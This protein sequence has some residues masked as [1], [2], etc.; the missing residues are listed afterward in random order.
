M[1]SFEPC[2]SDVAVVCGNHINAH[3]LV[4]N[5]ERIG[6]PGRIVLLRQ[7]VEGA[8]LAVC[9]NPQV[10]HWA[11]D[12]RSHDDLPARIEERYGREGRAVV[13]FTDERYHP[14]FAAWRRLHP[15]SPL[16][17]HLGS[18]A[19][20][21]AV[22]DRY[23]FCRF[24]ADRRLASVPRTIRGDEDPF[25]AFGDSFVVRPRL[26]WFGVAQRERVTLVKGPAEFRAAV[27]T[28]AS[29]GLRTEDLSFQELLS[30]RNRDNV[31]ISGWYGPEVRH[32]FC[33]RK[34]LQYPPK[35][36]GGDVVEL[37]SPPPGVMEQAQDVLAALSYEGPFELEFVFD[38]NAREFKVTELNPRFWLQQGLIEAASGCALIRAYLG[39][40][41]LPA[42]EAEQ[43]LRYWVNPLY[44]LYR[45]RNLDFRGLAYW[46]S[47]RAWA[48]F[49]L[50][51]AV[52]Y[53]WHYARR[54]VCHAQ[55]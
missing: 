49:S 11:A 10:E 32:L 46:S 5:L 47:R 53:G 2:K 37:V 21:T 48:P 51:E 55:G 39:Q 34:I 9:L 54:K 33:S 14:A 18:V 15:E 41:P 22:L 6:W 42:T 38:E 7:E 44:A 30:I 1:N 40:A 43:E 27:E 31:S 45:A 29:R 35:T 28:Y 24:I 16:R 4:R 36:G 13:F 17:F 23:E 25:A 26:S 19:H 20:M 52:R 50:R 12:V 3:T 8:G